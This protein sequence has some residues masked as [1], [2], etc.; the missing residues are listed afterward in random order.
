VK[1]GI[2]AFGFHQKLFELSWLFL[3]LLFSMSGLNGCGWFFFRL[4]Q[5]MAAPDLV[6][7]LYTR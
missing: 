2:T 3:V 7:V 4:R 1:S 6:I 5:M